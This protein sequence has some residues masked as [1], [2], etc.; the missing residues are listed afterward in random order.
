MTLVDEVLVLEVY[1][2]VIGV[3]YR[4]VSGFDLVCP[5]AVGPALLGD[6]KGGSE[7]TGNHVRDEHF[8]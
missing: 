5:P 7:V 2:V 1:D 3:F 8:I 6:G 4:L